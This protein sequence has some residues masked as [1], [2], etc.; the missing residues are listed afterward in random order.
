MSA[1]A[2]LFDS[3]LDVS[4]TL[5]RDHGMCLPPQVHMVAEDMDKPY[6]G[7]VSCRPFY[8]G[9]D[10]VTAITDLGQFPSVLMATHLLVAWEDCDMR[11]ALELPGDHFATGIALLDADFEQHTLR[12]HPYDIEWGPAGESGAPTVIPHWGTPA[13]YENPPLLAPFQALL[14]TWREL[15]NDDIQQTAVRLQQ[16]G[17]ELNMIKH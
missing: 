16:A 11:T 4:D 17:Y 8:R 10:A 13:H 12:W 3:L 6:V 15:R 14:D 1:T 7:F 5:L 2:F 9:A